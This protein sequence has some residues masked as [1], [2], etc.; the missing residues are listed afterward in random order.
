MFFLSKTVIFLKGFWHCTV[1]SELR[2]KSS[3]CLR[4]CI[5]RSLLLLL[6]CCYISNLEQVASR[7]EQQWGLHRRPRRASFGHQWQGVGGDVLGASWVGLLLK[8]LSDLQTS[9]ASPENVLKLLFALKVIII[10]ARLCLETLPK[11]LFK[12]GIEW[13]S[14]T[15][16]MPCKASFVL[17]GK[18]AK[19]NLQ[20][21]WMRGLCDNLSAP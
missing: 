11:K 6:S 13:S 12:T 2:K 16:M 7:S 19:N 20:R 14:L 9:I 18:R 1:P 17:Q 5:S 15:L 10:H 21:F 8:R 4:V 3:C